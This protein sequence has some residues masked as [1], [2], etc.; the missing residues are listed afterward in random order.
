[1]IL[2]TGSEGFIASHL[3]DHLLNKGFSVR[4]FVMYNSLSSI[5]WLKDINHPNLSIYFGNVRDY[6]SV[7]NSFDDV[8][9][10]FHLAALISI[11]YSYDNTLGYL[12]VNIIGTYNILE[13]VKN[14]NQVK[15]LFVTSTS[16]VYGS[17][18]Y[19]PIDEKHPL[20]AQSP[21]A[22][23]KIAADKLAESYYKSF[24]T[25]VT[26]IRP[27]NTYGP[28]QSTRAII[29]RI[30]TQLI[31]HPNEIKLGSLFPIRDFNFVKDVVAAMYS[32][33]ECDKSIG[34]EVNIAS[35]FGITI[36][37][38]IYKI[39]FI[40]NVD[41]NVVMD[42]SRV[43]PDSSEVDRLIG[44]AV[45]INSLTGWEST[46]SLEEGLRETIDFYLKDKI[47]ETDDYIK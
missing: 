29:P 7:V 47:T 44:D 30:I 18:Q 34:L 36:S 10:V 17:A 5:G 15:R 28:R 23:S 22:A 35:G 2:V 43:R 6:Q 13:A 41:F 16:E 40:M 24:G 9:V 31:Q 46:T 45:L 20:Q 19:I 3:V 33:I 25:P 4:A 1:M 37:D 21:Y 42:S 12:D 32:L 27:F 26:I 14:S 8:E 11:P 38:L 39:A